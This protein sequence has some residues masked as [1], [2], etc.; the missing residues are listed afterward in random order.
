MSTFLQFELSMLEIK[1]NSPSTSN[2]RDSTVV[3]YMY[4][5]FVTAW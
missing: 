4:Q 2:L 3:V 1:P 5:Y